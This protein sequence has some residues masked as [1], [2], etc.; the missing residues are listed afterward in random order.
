MLPRPYRT[1][2]IDSLPAAAA[3]NED[4]RKKWIW[5]SQKTATNFQQFNIKQVNFD[6]SGNSNKS[7]IMHII[8]KKLTG[9]INTQI[10]QVANKLM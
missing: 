1:V 10:N 8:Y 6:I 2:A 3:F 4:W 7:S 9:P 5:L